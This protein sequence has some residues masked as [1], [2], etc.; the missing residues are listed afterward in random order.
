MKWILFFIISL[1]LTLGTGCGPNYR[2][3]TAPNDTQQQKIRWNDYSETLLLT[4]SLSK[5]PALLYF[6]AKWCNV[7]KKMEEETFSNEKV[8]Y[9]INHEFIP[10]VI[11]DASEQFIKIAK[12][13]EILKDEDDSVPLPA[14]VVFSSTNEPEVIAKVIGLIEP[15]SL[16]T[17]LNSAQSVNTLII[18]QKDLDLLFNL[19]IKKNK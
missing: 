9:T 17:V 6:K 18:M 10:L 5:K 7:C 14:L 3:Y 13:S 19:F 15:D 8:A 11:T 12:F 4:S 16:L 2:V 1:C